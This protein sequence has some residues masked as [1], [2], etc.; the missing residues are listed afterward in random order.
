[1]KVGIRNRLEANSLPWARDNAAFRGSGLSKQQ[2]SSP[3]RPHFG[4]T[5]EKP[6]QI[7]SHLRVAPLLGTTARL[8]PVGLR[9]DIGDSMRL[10]RGGTIQRVGEIKHVS[11]ND[12]RNS[13]RSDARRLQQLLRVVEPEIQRWPVRPGYSCD[14]VCASL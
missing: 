10:A 12:S 11:S 13:C 4:G 9:S 14:S 1:M 6:I 3:Y 8:T 5:H 7:L 2:S